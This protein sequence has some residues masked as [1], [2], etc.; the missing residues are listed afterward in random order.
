M[1]D[2]KETEAIFAHQ[3]FKGCKMGAIISE[4]GDIWSENY[5]MVFS[6]HIHDFQ[7]PQRNI[8]YP[9]TPFQ[10]GFGDSIDKFLVMIDFKDRTNWGMEKIYLDI[11]KKKSITINILDLEDYIFPENYILKIKLLGDTKTSNMILSKPSVREKLRKHNIHYK[12]K[13]PEIKL[14]KREGNFSKN[15]FSYNL[16][17]RIKNS[18]SE[19]RKTFSEIF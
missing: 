7:Q 16:E 5:P 14:K 9:G 6:G 11:I 17:R 3:E 18:D 19:I 13:N 1:L 8:L 4:T 10:H 12:L 2:P 15:T